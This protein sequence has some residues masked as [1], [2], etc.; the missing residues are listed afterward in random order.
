MD[1]TKKLSKQDDGKYSK[2]R[3]NKLKKDVLLELEKSGFIINKKEL[4]HDPSKENLRKLHKSAVEDTQKKYSRTLR[5]KEHKMIQYIAN[6]T[7]IDPEEIDPILIQINSDSEYWDLFN[8]IKIHWSIPISKGYGKRLCYI[9]FDKN[10]DKAMGIIGLQD[11]VISIPQRDHYIGWDKTCKDKNI[12]LVM[13]G[14][15]IGSVPPYNMILGGKLISSLLFSNQIR[16]D[17]Y[18]KY[19]GKKSLILGRT[20]T[21]ELAL[22]TTLSALGKSAMYDR[23][24]L[25]NK[26]K[27]I[28]IGYSHGYG[29]FHFNG[30]VYKRMKKLAYAYKPPSYKKEEWGIGYRNKRE[31]VYKALQVLNIPRNYCKH[32]VK[33]ELFLA[34]LAKNYKHVLSQNKKPDYYNITVEEITN[35]MKKRWVIPRSIRISDYKNWN[36]DKYLIWNQ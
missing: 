32:G 9:V 8:Y 31:V 2:R 13:D 22:I 19:C 3:I 29:E 7:D 25:P 10:T 26:Q 24:Q 28:S 27:F 33:R 14:Y 12:N 11:P 17:F 35:F 36:N 6:G 15:V 1:G 20:H 23:I 30:A 16:K 18:K 4:E 34:P 5:K 21:G